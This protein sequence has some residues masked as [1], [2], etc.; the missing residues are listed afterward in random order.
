M[1][2]T[3]PI[4]DTSALISKKSDKG[5]ISVIS[6]IEFIIWAMRKYRDIMKVNKERALGYLN[7][8]ASLP[9]ILEEYEILELKN[10]R[11]L[12]DLVYYVLEK[13]LDPA[14]G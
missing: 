9:Y 5:K 8:I 7:L 12:E 1:G 10:R 3:E 2:E 4:V 13:D 6:I 11:E 14:D